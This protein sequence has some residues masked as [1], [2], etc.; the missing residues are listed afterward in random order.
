MLRR[1]LLGGFNYWVGQ[2]FSFGR[3]LWITEFTCPSNDGA[4]SLTSLYFMYVTRL[5]RCMD[6]MV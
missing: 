2:A 6:V 1:G 4:Y 5:I 3:P